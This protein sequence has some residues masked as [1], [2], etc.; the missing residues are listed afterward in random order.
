MW[1][2]GVLGSWGVL[3]M[4]K[5][6]HEFLKILNLVSMIGLRFHRWELTLRCNSRNC[7]R[8]GAGQNLLKNKRGYYLWKLLWEFLKIQNFTSMVSP[9]FISLILWYKN[10]KH[11]MRRVGLDSLWSE[12]RCCLWNFYLLCLTCWGQLYG[13][14]T[15]GWDG[16]NNFILDMFILTP[17]DFCNCSWKIH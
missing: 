2:G 5:T 13:W 16:C 14:G 3:V 9:V 10:C 6:A 11:C 8:R 7:C 12:C 15:M 4:V 17:Q 1:S